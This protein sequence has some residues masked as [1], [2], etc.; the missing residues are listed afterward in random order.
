MATMSV[1]ALPLRKS[2]ADVHF[3]ADGLEGGMGGMNQYQVSD[4]L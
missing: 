1:L 3:P 4:W 2:T